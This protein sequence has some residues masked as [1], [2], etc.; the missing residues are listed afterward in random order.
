MIEINTAICIRERGNQDKI[1]G[2]GFVGKLNQTACQGP[3]RISKHY[4]LRSAPD[5]AGSCS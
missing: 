5:S 4:S 2:W 1:G 3:T